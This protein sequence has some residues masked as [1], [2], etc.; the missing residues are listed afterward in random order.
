[1][2]FYYEGK[3]VR[4]SKTHEYHYGIYD[5]HYK[6][7]RSCHSTRE[8]AE[9]ELNT[10]INQPL[11]WIENEKNAI[12]ALQSGKKYYFAKE[13]NRNICVRFTKEDTVEMWEGYIKGNETKHEYRKSNLCVVEL[14]VRN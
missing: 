1:M 7:M 8:L 6:T 10:Y 11:N 14:E 2:K 13:G 5:K 3:L 12:K 9:K 4:T